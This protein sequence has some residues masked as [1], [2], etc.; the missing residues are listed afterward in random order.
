[1]IESRLARPRLV[2]L[3]T[4]SGHGD[5]HRVP[6]GLPVPDA[7]GDVVA[8]QSGHSDVEDRDVWIQEIEHRHRIVAV[9]GDV[10][11]VSVEAQQHR[12]ALSRILIVVR[13]QHEV[14]TG[15]RHRS[16]RDRGRSGVRSLLLVVSRV[17]WEPP[18]VECLASADKTDDSYNGTA[19][20]DATSSMFRQML[21]GPT[22]A[23][24]P[25]DSIDGSIASCNP[26]SNTRTR[27]FWRRPTITASVSRPVASTNGTL[28]RR[29]TTV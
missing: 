26:H 1:M 21:S 24:M 13:D 12:E 28:P 25:A 5:Q 17:S 9:A 11:F 22:S 18:L 27:A 7:P 16:S 23:R 8:A 29:I 4:P 3:L 20:R 15:S 19:A 14:F 10:H 6:T 2:R